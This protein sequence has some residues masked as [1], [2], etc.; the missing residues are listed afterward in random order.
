MSV[1]RSLPWLHSVDAKLDRA[2]EHLD[3]INRDIDSFIKGTTYEFVPKANQHTNEASIV[4]WMNEPMHPPLSISVE[5]GEF[6][7]N[8]R[9]ALDNL[10]CALVRSVKGM[11]ASCSGNGFP[12]HTNCDN[13]EAESPRALKGVPPAARTLIQ[14]LQPYSRGEQ[15]AADVDPLSILNALRNRD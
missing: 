11:G 8:L 12:I 2:H 14:G 1:V 5:I 3:I 6:L 7:Y 10:V 13:F 4:W 9:S 15:Q